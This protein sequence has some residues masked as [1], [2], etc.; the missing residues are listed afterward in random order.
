VQTGLQDERH[1]EILEGL[2][3]NAVV[4]LPDTSFVLPGKKGGS[5]PFMPQRSRTR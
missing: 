5:N 4:L 1:I 2:K 3:D